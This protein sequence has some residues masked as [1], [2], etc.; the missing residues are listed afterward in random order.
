LRFPTESTDI[1]IVDSLERLQYASSLLGI[2]LLK[3]RNI[4][5]IDSTARVISDSRVDTCEHGDGDDISHSIVNQA[6]ANKRSKSIDKYSLTT[7]TK[8]FNRCHASSLKPPIKS[9]IQVPLSSSPS[10][11]S[12]PSVEDGS[13][14]FRH[15]VGLDAEWKSYNAGGS[16]GCSILQV[17]LFGT[18]IYMHTYTQLRCG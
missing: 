14:V 17:I 1:L 11:S 6:S 5:G 13:R 2:D 10:S 16:I 7:L 4:G 15:V 8:K 9:F 18:L 12:S 3:H